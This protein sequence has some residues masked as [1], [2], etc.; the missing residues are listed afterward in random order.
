M[1]RASEKAAQAAAAPAASYDA[2]VSRLEQVVA[3]LEAG[4]LPLEGS[5]EKFAEGIQLARDAARRLDEAEA[6]VEQL[7]RGADGGEE[8]A[9]FEPERG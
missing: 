9:P 5:V 8:A 6:R 4:D 2:L 1:A 3:A 7:V